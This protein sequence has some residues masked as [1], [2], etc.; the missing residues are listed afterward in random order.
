[1]SMKQRRHILCV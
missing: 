1:L